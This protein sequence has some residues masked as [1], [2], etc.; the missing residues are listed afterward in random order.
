MHPRATSIPRVG[1]PRAFT[2]I[3]V[4]LVVAIAAVLSAIALPR[5]NNSLDRYR[6]EL[7]AQRIATDLDYA[8]TYARHA[9]QSIK[10][11]FDINTDR[12]AAPTLPVPDGRNLR[13][14]LD[15]SEEP[16]A[17]DLTGSD[18]SGQPSVTFNG[19]GLPDS[20]G[21][22]KLSHGGRVVTLTLDANTG[23]ITLP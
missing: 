9:S 2:L 15:L 18:F 16:F 12:L 13:Y 14:Q 1:L 8:R 21:T 23:R 10:V 11:N 17:V 7:A 4:V 22:I 3:E 20:P 5:F 6:L 19:H